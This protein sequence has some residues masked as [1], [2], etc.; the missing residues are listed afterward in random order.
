MRSLDRD[1]RDQRAIPEWTVPVVL[2][3]V[4]LAVRSWSAAQVTFPPTEGSAYYVGVAR[5]LIAG[6]GLV[7]D[8][9]WSY[10][11]PPLVLP[12][13]AFDLWMPLAS[14]IAAIPMA[15]LGPTLASAQLGFSILGAALAPLAWV[16]ARDEAR[17]RDLSRERVAMVA[18]AAGVAAGLLGPLVTTAMAPDSTLPFAV[19]ATG[20]ALVMSRL[21]TSAQAAEAGGLRLPAVALGLLLGLAYLARQ[22]AIYLVVACLVLTGLAARRLSPERGVRLWR[23]VALSALVAGLLVTAWLARNALTFDASPFRQAVEVAFFRDN[24]DLF[25]YADRPALAGFL[26]QGP[27]AI[28][29]HQVEALV[30]NLV[31]VVLIAAAPVGL[32]GLLGL[33]VDRRRAGSPASPLAVLLV[34]GALAYLGTSLVFPV[35]SRWGTFFHGSGP[36]VVALIV[37]AALFLDR[38]LGS[39]RELRRWPRSNA[40]LAPVTLAV[41]TAP[42]AAVHIEST[43]RHAA[44][45]ARLVQAGASAVTGD[46]RPVLT[47]HPV[48]LAEVRGRPALALPD[49]SPAQVRRLA[50]RFGA[51]HI[52]L[53]DGSGRE[54]FSVAAAEDSGCFR[55]VATGTAG[56]DGIEVLTTRG[57]TCRA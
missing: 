39:L 11:T 38:V 15:L 9:L 51:D 20:A 41:L 48:W 44:G 53:F 36:L 18:V 49:E 22:E 12:K 1:G 30:D 6:D 42:L 4:A 19:A 43:A 37:L 16:V 31:E 35:A 33:A 17:L 23:C 25:A 50:D 32:L 57:T 45:F 52:V 3:A 27:A 2:F 10:A 14:F 55:R 7:S 13:P 8:A 29:A 26:A 47:D 34:T 24:L 40:W 54:S 28:L 5:N 21:V 56:S 46:E